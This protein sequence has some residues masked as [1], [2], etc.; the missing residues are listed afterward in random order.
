MIVEIAKSRM[1]VVD[2]IAAFTT[3]I[4]YDC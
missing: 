3:D 2:T 4:C 1:S